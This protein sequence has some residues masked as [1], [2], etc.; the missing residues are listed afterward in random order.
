MDPAMRTDITLPE[1]FLDVFPDAS[2][3]FV[4][5]VD[6]YFRHL[7][8]LVSIDLS[9]VDQSLSGKVHLVSPVEPTDGVIGEETWSFHTYY[10]RSNWIGFKLNGL[11]KYELLSDF[12]FFEIEHD[13][14]DEERAEELELQSSRFHAAYNLAIQRFHNYGSLRWF[15]TRTDKAPRVE[16]EP[17][18]N[19]LGGPAPKGNWQG[20]SEF[21]LDNSDP[22][23][24]V[25]L[26][27]NGRKF[28]FIASATPWRYAQ[29]DGTSEW[30]QFGA[31]GILL[32]FEPVERI[33]LQTFEWG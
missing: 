33:V 11:N 21:P 13:S 29:D 12:R 10:C 20:H 4:E 30:M 9:T 7:L 25:P 16:P 17:I 31:D 32:F 5:P 19:Q 24:V 22:A 26:S 18:L 8:P 28:Q 27:M 3:V 15:S 1:P 6:R 14:N 2:K 23:N